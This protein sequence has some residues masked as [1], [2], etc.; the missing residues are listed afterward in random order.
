MITKPK[1]PVVQTVQTVQK[2]IES[3]F[4]IKL[5]NGLIKGKSQVDLKKLVSSMDTNLKNAL[6]LIIL[7]YLGININ[8]EGEIAIDDEKKALDFVQWLQEKEAFRNSK[9]KQKISLTKQRYATA[10]VL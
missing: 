10:D 2:D 7:N 8:T 3:T 6:S 5:F 9:P 1:A 4:E